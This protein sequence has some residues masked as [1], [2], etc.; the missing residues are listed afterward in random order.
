VTL[1]AAASRIH[2]I[3]LRKFCDWLSGDKSPLN[4]LRRNA[5]LPADPEK[6]LHLRIICLQEVGLTLT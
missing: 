2:G 6:Q 1:L 4:K 3:A 5:V